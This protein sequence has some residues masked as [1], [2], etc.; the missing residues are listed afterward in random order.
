M[1]RIRKHPAGKETW[2]GMIFFFLICKNAMLSDQCKKVSVHRTYY[3]LFPQ[4]NSQWLKW[5]EHFYTHF[6]CKKCTAQLHAETGSGMEQCRKLSNSN[7]KPINYIYLVE[8]RTEINKTKYHCDL[9]KNLNTTVN[10][11]Y[12]RKKPIQVHKGRQ[13]KQEEKHYIMMLL[14]HVWLTKNTKPLGEQHI[15]V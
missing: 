6:R 8:L 13:S 14:F 1:T 12:V 15:G 4:P 7:V 3:I 9:S 11:S 5:S 2:E 10:A